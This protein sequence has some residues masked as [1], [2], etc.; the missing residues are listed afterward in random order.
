MKLLCHLL[1]ALVSAM[2]SSH[3]IITTVLDYGVN[4]F[5]ETSDCGI[6]NR[7]VKFSFL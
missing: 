2:N 1:K 3:C 5:A 4:F 6:L 7:C